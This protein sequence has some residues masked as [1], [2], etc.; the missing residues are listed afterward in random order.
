MFT[1]ANNIG[2]KG[3]KLIAESLKSNKSLKELELR[4]ILQ[5]LFQEPDTKSK[6]KNM[7]NNIGNEGARAFEES[8][9]KNKTLKTLGLKSASNNIKMRHY[10]CV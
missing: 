1:L 5:T 7:D 2:D 9:K 6:S 4:S 8:L 3:A 10:F